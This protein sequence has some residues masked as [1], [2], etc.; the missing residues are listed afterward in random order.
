[1]FCGEYVLCVRIYACE[2]MC[3]VCE[4]MCNMYVCMCVSIYICIVESVCEYIHMYCGEC[5]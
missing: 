4:Y 5:V 3:I 2:Y 1:M